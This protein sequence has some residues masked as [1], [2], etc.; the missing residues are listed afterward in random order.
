MTQWHKGS[1]DSEFP[2]LNTDHVPGETSLKP[3]GHVVRGPEPGLQRVQSGPS[4]DCQDGWITVVFLAAAGLMETFHWTWMQR[5]K[6]TWCEMALILKTFHFRIGSVD[7]CGL[8][9]VASLPWPR[10]VSPSVWLNPTNMDFIL[11]HDT[12]F[13]TFLENFS[14]FMDFFLWVFQRLTTAVGLASSE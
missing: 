8:F 2:T 7:V 11:M 6:L 10:L 3:V 4:A 13:T 9:A 12:F 5:L 14:L 1:S